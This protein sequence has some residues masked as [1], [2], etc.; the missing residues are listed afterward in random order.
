ME[1]FPRCAIQAIE[2]K[3][4]RGGVRFAGPGF[5]GGEDMLEKRTNAEAVEN[6]GEP[7]VEIGNDRQRAELGGGLKK[8]GRLGIELPGRR[9]G[10]VVEEGAEVC[11]ER[12]FLILKGLV[13]SRVDKN[14][15][16][17]PAPPGPFRSV[18][19]RVPFVVG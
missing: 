14:L 5:S 16:H 1:G 10:V 4:E 7:V 6:G 19:R 8:F 2:G 9:S 13:S 3:V 12:A 15:P 18:S 17:Q 11:L